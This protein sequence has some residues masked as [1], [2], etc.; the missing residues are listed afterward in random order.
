MTGLVAD[1]NREWSGSH[2]EFAS[3]PGSLRRP[4]EA[5]LTTWRSRCFAAL[6]AL[7]A[8][9][10]AI[11][12]GPAGSPPGKLIGIGSHVL[13]INCAG[14][15][16]GPTV[17]FESGLGGT[18]LDW[19]RV[20][21]EVSRFARACSYDRSG[22]GFSERGP[23]LARS[24]EQVVDELET[25]LVYASLPPPYV[26]VG[27]SLGGMSMRL[28]AHRNPEVVA[29]LVLVDAT[30]EQQFERF[31]AAG[32]RVPAV[33]NRRSFVI[34]NQWQIP[35]GLPESVRTVAQS[36]VLR[37]GAVRS[38]YD[39]LFHM[40][41][42]ARQMIAARPH[43]PDVPVHVLVHGKSPGTSPDSVLRYR[44]WRE[45]QSE[46]AA[47]GSRGELMVAA[48]SGHYIHLDEPEL[49]VNAIRSIVANL[50]EQS[51]AAQRPVGLRLN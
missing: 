12:A 36:L 2:C 32:L 24:T 22:Y 1:P 5:R 34:S 21:P 51:G 46:L 10:A 26:L 23:A 29:G 47:Q 44:L 19:V 42:S 3:E 30:H 9:V 16:N 41:D 25:L 28:F 45:L 31:A 48:D 7:L 6:L 13:H 33:P 14:S 49:V 40:Q 37:P 4:H 15:R 8:P 39:E 20:Q 35:E 27:H 17:L 50:Q 11:S 18:W 43:L 38:L